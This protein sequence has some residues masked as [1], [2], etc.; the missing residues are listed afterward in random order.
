MYSKY[1]DA[2]EATVVDNI[3]DISEDNIPTILLAATDDIEFYK[4]SISELQEKVIS[5]NQRV[6]YS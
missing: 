5:S 3:D 6:W 1:I 4:K 2:K